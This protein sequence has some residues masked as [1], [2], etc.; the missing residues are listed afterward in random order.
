[1]APLRL[2]LPHAPRTDPSP[3]ATRP[4]CCWVST[5]SRGGSGRERWAACPDAT[6]QVAPAWCVKGCVC[7]V[8]RQHA[9]VVR[10]QLCKGWQLRSGPR[11]R[12]SA[13][14]FDECVV[15]AA[16]D[17]HD[18]HAA[19]GAR[20]VR[21]QCVCIPPRVWTGHSSSLVGGS[22]GRQASACP[23]LE[24]CAWSTPT[25]PPPSLGQPLHDAAT[26]SGCQHG[27]TELT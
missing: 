2:R 9:A 11:V 19:C 22:C 16:C 13:H 7:A 17:A 4:W 14:C 8:R 27:S 5:E 26:G 10:P 6:E 1:M 21:A 25:I 20:S 3:P 24:V 15:C 18:A 12:V 23:A